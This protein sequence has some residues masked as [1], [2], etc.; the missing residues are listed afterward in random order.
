MLRQNRSY[1]RVVSFVATL[2][3]VAC[4]NP[5][6]PSPRPGTTVTGE[7][8]AAGAATGVGA[9]AVPV[10]VFRT[11]PAANALDE[12][13]GYFPLTVNFN[14][15]RSTDPDPGDSLRYT[16]DFDADGTVD[17]R[18]TCRA[19]YT[20]HAPARARVC[21]SD[22]TPDGEVC[23]TYAIAPTPPEPEAAP[24]FESAPADG[25]TI[26]LSAALGRTS[27]TSLDIS[28]SGDD[29]L[30]A[31]PSGLSGV[32]SISPSTEQSIAEGGTQAFTISCSPAAL[33]TTTQTLTLTTN[34]AD[35][36]TNTYTVQCT[37]TKPWPDAGCYYSSVYSLY[38]VWDG[39]QTQGPPINFTWDGTCATPPHTGVAGFVFVSAAN[40]SDAAGICV[41]KGHIFI[42]EVSSSADTGAWP[43]YRCQIP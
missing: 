6:A 25:A 43:I 3:C 40:A 17:F 1:G 15:C 42:D 29:V 28:N 36:A 37:G 38:I 24:E 32:L 26:T 22:R 41:S 35:E 39:N 31:A 7:G 23:K 18:G 20:Y 19:S 5:S 30:T 34:D 13:Y 12:I 8:G 33:A 2:A 16:F 9:L 21:V 10:A 11:N 4:S 14:L 27:T